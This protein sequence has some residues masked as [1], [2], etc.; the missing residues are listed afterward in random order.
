MTDEQR[1]AAAAQALRDTL[2]ISWDENL[3][4]GR[5]K[6]ENIIACAR[7][8]VTAVMPPQVEK[9]RA[10]IEHA[11]EA[12]ERGSTSAPVLECLKAASRSEQ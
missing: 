5:I 3:E 4:M 11:I 9:L 10:T 7:A 12:I 1:V 8:M 2:R 6:E